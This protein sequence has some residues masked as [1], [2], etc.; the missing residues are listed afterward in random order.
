[1]RQEASTNRRIATARRRASAKTSRQP[2]TAFNWARLWSKLHSGIMPCIGSWNSW[3]PCFDLEA[4][5]FVEMMNLRVSVN[6]TCEIF[7]LGFRLIF[8]SLKMDFIWVQTLTPRVLEMFFQMSKF[9]TGG[10]FFSTICWR[11]GTNVSINREG[12][13]HS[14]HLICLSL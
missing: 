1:M 10:P 8:L 12:L 6:V 9:G 11:Q 13:W 4:P 3:G 14:F 7:V 2:K 5:F